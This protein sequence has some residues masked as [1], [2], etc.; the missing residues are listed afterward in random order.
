MRVL[1]LAYMPV[2]FFACGSMLV[3]V[4]RSAQNKQMQQL[5]HK[6]E[7]KLCQNKLFIK[8]TCVMVVGFYVF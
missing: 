8:C 7:T 4:L 6:I 2:T 3:R 5:L 1:H